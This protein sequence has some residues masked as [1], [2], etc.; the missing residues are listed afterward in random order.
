MKIL[1]FL[2]LPFLCTASED[3]GELANAA[4]GVRAEFAAD[5]LLR[6]ASAA[7]ASK[8]QK[9]EWIEQAFERA[10]GAQQ[11]YKRRA[12]IPGIES[13]RY[14]NRVYGQDLDGLSLRLRAVEAMMPLDAAKAREMFTHLPPVHLPVVPCEEFR[15]YD[16]DR[17]YDVLA[18]V[19]GG[20]GKFL[21]KYAGTVDSPVEAGPA[22][23]LIARSGAQDEDFRALLAAYAQALGRIGG[24]DRSFTSAYAVGRDI[25]SLAAEAKRRGISAMPLLENYRVYLVIHYS[26]SRCADNDLM[27]A[28][29]VT[30][31]IVNAAHDGPMDPIAFF[32]QK[33]R[34]A[35]LQPIGELESTPARI[36]GVATGLRACEDSECRHITEMYRGLVLQ[37]G[38]TTKWKEFLEAVDSWKGSYEMK[39]WAYSNLLALV[40]D[41]SARDQVVQ[42]MLAFVAQNPLQA[43]NPME[44]FLPVNALIARLQLEGKDLAALRQSTDPVIALYAGLEKAAPRPNDKLMLLQ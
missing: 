37:R 28:G 1:A 18:A 20:D 29:G 6:L 22:A 43:S 39:T 33:L 17:F 41:A 38:G 2:I 36:E 23:R 11:P 4:R 32:N 19:A 10:A 5:A 42:A 16:V 34:A 13:A 31:G 12:V 44:W 15:V 35:P 27:G 26:L 9:V 25:E 24:D 40:S 14:W 30:V 8:A 3:L 7:N 21:L